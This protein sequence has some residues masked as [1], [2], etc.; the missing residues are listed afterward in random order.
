METGDNT[1]HGVMAGLVPFSSITLGC[2]SIK[3][4]LSITQTESECLSAGGV[5]NAKQGLY[6]K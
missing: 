5:I 6:T 2:N 1:R 4:L 3:Q